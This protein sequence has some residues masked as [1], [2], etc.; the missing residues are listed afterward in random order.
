MD[1]HTAFSV[2]CCQGKD[3][4]VLFSLNYSIHQLTL[5]LDVIQL[6]D[7]NFFNLAKLNSAMYVYCPFL[8]LSFYLSKSE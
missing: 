4:G 5:A 2:N 1:L 7:R 3:A 6:L 8:S